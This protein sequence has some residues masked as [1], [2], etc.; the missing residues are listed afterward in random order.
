MK[1]PNKSNV[2]EMQALATIAEMIMH[3]NL[4]HLLNISAEDRKEL[5]TVRQR[6]EKIIHNNGYSMDYRKD[7]KVNLKEMQ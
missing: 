7:L 3:F 1:K 6:L 4:L 2:T 5:R